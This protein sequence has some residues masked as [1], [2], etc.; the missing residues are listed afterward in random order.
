MSTQHNDKAIY[1][2]YCQ[3]LWP[4]SQN[5][6]VPDSV[7]TSKFIVFFSFLQPPL[8]C[9]HWSTFNY[10]RHL[11][12]RCQSSS[13]VSTLSQMRHNTDTCI[14]PKCCFDQGISPSEALVITNYTELD[15]QEPSTSISFFASLIL[16]YSLAS[17]LDLPEK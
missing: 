14:F 4:L 9:Q 12:T 15:R 17:L 11:L 10:R 1:S 16:H 2:Y 8:W 7:T 5:A 13:S 6:L 3:F